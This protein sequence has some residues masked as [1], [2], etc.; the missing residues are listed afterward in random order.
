MQKEG[1]QLNKAQREAVEAIFGPLLVIA[2]PGT[3]K[4][5]LLAARAAEI[6]SKTDVG[7]NSVLCLT[8]TEAGAVAMRRRLVSMIG[9]DGYKVPVHT[10][11]GFGQSVINQHQEYFGIQ[12]EAADE[13]RQLTILDKLYKKFTHNNPL[14]RLL[15]GEF[16]SMRNLLTAISEIRKGGYSPDEIKQVIVQS[17]AELSKIQPIF[18]EFVNKPRMSKTS[19]AEVLQI[20]G[21]IEAKS[22]WTGSFINSLREAAEESAETGKTTP[23]TTWRNDWYEHDN[24]AT[25]HRIPKDIRR[26]E[27]LDA[28]ADVYAQYQ[29]EMKQQNLYDFEDMILEVLQ[30]VREHDALRYDLQEQYQFIMVDEFQDTNGAQLQ[31][32][33]QL[34]D[35]PV[36]EGRPN[37]MA[38][39]DD[40]QGIYKFQGA[41]VSNLLDFVNHFKDVKQIVLTDNYRSSEGIL[42]I[43]RHAIK[44][45]ESRLENTLE[46]INKQ[47]EAK[48]EQGGG[49]I[50]LSLHDNREAEYAWVASEI[51]RLIDSGTKPQEIAVLNPRRSTLKR[52]L[53]YLDKLSVP[54]HFDQRASVFEQPAVQALLTLAETVQLLA[55][56]R[57]HDADAKLAESL[58]D[59]MWGVDQ[60]KVWELSRR[61]YKE[62]KFWMELMPD[63]DFAPIVR[64]V[65]E[66]AS[67]SKR[68]NL[69]HMLDRLI[70]NVEVGDDLISP[71]KKHYFKPE[72]L[73]AT[74]QEYLSGL[75]AIARLRDVTTNYAGEQIASLSDLLDVVSLYQS[76]NL[77]LVDTSPL[78]IEPEAVQ[79]MTAYGSKGLE[80]E[81][82]FLLDAEEKAW[83][84]PRG[85]PTLISYPQNLPLAPAGEN[86]DDWLRLFYVAL[87][88]AKQHL[89]LS[90]AKVNDRGDATMPVQFLVDHHLDEKETE[91]QPEDKPAILETTLTAQKLDKSLRDLL[92]PILDSYV[93]SPTHLNAWIN[94]EDDLQFIRDYILHF[95]QAISS[96][97][98]YGN[99]IH[100]TLEYIFKNGRERGRLPDPE[101]FMKVF[102]DKLKKQYLTDQDFEREL[103]RGGEWLPKFVKAHEQM[104][105]TA[106]ESEFSFYDQHLAVE[107]VAISGKLDLLLRPA[108]NQ[109]AILD[110]KTGKVEPKWR[111]DPRKLDN[112]KRQ[113]IFYQ[114]LLSNSPLFVGQEVVE[115]GLVFVE[116]EEDTRLTYEVT[117][118]DMDDLIGRMVE[119]KQVLTEL[120]D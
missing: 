33:Y 100:N 92:K 57:H 65:E 119:M 35:N 4:T 24:K 49:A 54:Y 42:E 43:S 85:A 1:I 90:R 78:I 99:A 80:F 50:S 56:G 83:V 10:F 15:G 19:S 7:P 82:V 37:V 67:Q 118:A 53:P 108:K 63:T 93:L 97:A 105:T 25:K 29:A 113:L 46:H 28:A 60:V 27:V 32:L 31:L 104:L 9:D 2:G 47:L 55:D 8:Y 52:L 61:A 69:H 103:A 6:I 71:L 91:T 62:R 66:L 81:A 36:H 106:G 44:K 89:Y 98:A 12:R 39:G 111:K 88:R 114:I 41:D 23:L 102:E 96:A 117:D 13:L 77:S 30:A 115:N 26:L 48:A 58:T 76:N 22:G 3:G 18:D 5:Q 101:A 40:D 95:P 94:R 59:P 11:H 51:Q 87:T 16:G 34:T 116:S 120:V 38:V 107:G 86:T 74:P 64:L 109:I 17:Q 112:Y 45:G 79:L 110:Y 68:L 21:G 75:S 14:K 72:N 84:K 20:L 73:E 70:G